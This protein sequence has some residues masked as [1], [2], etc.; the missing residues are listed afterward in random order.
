MYEKKQFSQHH[1]IESL[2]KLI[3]SYDYCLE[4]AVKDLDLVLYVGN[5]GF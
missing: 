2:R 1:G 3:I 4:L 5:V